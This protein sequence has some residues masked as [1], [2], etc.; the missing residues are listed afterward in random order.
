MK[1]FI[2]IQIKKIFNFIVNVLSSFQYGGFLLDNIIDSCLE[3]KYLVKHNGVEFKLNVPNKLCYWRAKTFS[4]KEPKTL[5]WID[6]FSTNSVFWDVGCNIGLYSIYAAKKNNFVYG[7]EPSFFNLE[8]IARNININNINNNFFVLPIALN[9]TDK[10]SELKL[11]SGVW[12]SAHSTFDKNYDGD[13]VKINEKFI[14]KTIG[15]S[16]DHILKVLKLPN[17]NYIKIDVDGI[18]H[19]IL[20][21]GKDVISKSKSILIENSKKFAEQ[22]NGIN[23]LLKELNFSMIDEFVINNDYSNQIWE[24]D[25]KII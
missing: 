24:N 17:P 4:S 10:M 19:L 12:G 22:H 18:E 11:T 5:E 2:K 20:K 13:G 15:F 16:M 25:K 3:R 8:I 6:K 7:F 14:Y 23:H 9:D 21:G 1:K